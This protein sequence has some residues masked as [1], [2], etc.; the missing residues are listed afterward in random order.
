VLGDDYHLIA[1]A[2]ILVNNWQREAR[3]CL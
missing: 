3:Y 1:H 2:D